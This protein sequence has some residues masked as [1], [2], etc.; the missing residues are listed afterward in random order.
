M[1]SLSVTVT[2]TET[3]KRRVGEGHGREELVLGIFFS[4][5]LELA[6]VRASGTR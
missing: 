4:A 1:Q 6:G 2:E 5:P 3:Q